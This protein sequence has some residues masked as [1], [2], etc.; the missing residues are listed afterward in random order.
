MARDFNIQV[1]GFLVLG[2][3]ARDL[4][5]QILDLVPEA[6]DLNIQMPGSPPP[7]PKPGI[8]YSNACLLRTW[9]K[10]RHSNSKGI[11][12]FENFGNVGP[13]DLNV[14][15]LGPLDLG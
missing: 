2:P 8:E 10:A 5:V 15:I 4:K 13:R 9:D 12:N 3:T 7:R 11:R 1:F 6:R 14:Q